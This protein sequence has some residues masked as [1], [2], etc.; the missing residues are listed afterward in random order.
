MLSA[1]DQGRQDSPVPPVLRQRAGQ[2]ANEPM[3]C[4]LTLQKFLPRG[5]RGLGDSDEMLPSVKL[6]MI[7]RISRLRRPSG[8]RWEGIRHPFTLRAPSLRRQAA[9]PLHFLLHAIGEF[10]T[11]MTNHPDDKAWLGTTPLL[12][13]SGFSC[14]ARG[15]ASKGHQA[16]DVCSLGQ[17]T[18]IQL[19]KRGTDIDVLI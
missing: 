18:L 10:M 7:E 3:S 1:E 2:R 14:L 15:G 4:C 9:A 13:L 16:L 11:L 19:R 8:C 5:L 6:L 17:I 12:L